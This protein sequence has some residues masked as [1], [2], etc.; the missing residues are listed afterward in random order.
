MYS[1]KCWLNI[2]IPF[3][4]YIDCSGIYLGNVNIFLPNELHFVAC[5]G[6]YPA[7]IEVSRVGC[8]VDIWKY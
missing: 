2:L 1:G 6:K 8:L 3:M 7:Q 5:L 4:K